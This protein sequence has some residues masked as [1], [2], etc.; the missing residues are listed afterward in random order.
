MKELETLNRQ[1]PDVEDPASGPQHK[2]TIGTVNNLGKMAETMHLQALADYEKA[3]GPEHTSALDT[4]DSLGTLY[5]DQGKIKE[6][7]AMYLRALKC[8]KKA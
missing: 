3:W 6:A 8:K 1:A 5:R 2:S 4:V 7:E